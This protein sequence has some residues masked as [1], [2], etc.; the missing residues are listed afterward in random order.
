VQKEKS[1]K[2]LKGILRES[3][4]YYIDLEKKIRHR[5]RLLP[6]GSVKARLISGRRY[7]YLQQRKGSKIVQKYLGRQKP[8]ELLRQMKERRELKQEAKKVREALRILRRSGVG[9]L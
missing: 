3:R 8:D 1:V 9:A 5:L 2:V 7:Y 6:Q 4:E